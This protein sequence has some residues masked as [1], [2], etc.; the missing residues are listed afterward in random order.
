MFY[1][2]KATETAVVQN[3]PCLS[4]PVNSACVSTKRA[5]L[6]CCQDINL[7]RSLVGR[8]QSVPEFCVRF[9]CFAKCNSAMWVALPIFHN[10]SPV[11]C[12]T[13][14]V[15]AMHV[16]IFFVCKRVRH[17]DYLTALQHKTATS[18]HCTCRNSIKIQ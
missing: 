10:S 2:L 14:T 1:C 6:H 18:R 7:L 13:K 16:R 9:K 8:N 12:T 5:S 17:T 15:S 3:S 11:I 4:L